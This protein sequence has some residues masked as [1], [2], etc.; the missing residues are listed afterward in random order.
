MHMH[1]GGVKLVSLGAVL[2]E[3]MCLRYASGLIKRRSMAG[4]VCLFGTGAG[5]MSD[6][7]W[8]NHGH[9]QCVPFGL[10]CCCYLHPD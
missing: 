3:G 6:R 10:F 2:W 9:A 1:V 7:F 8:A 5:G 4:T